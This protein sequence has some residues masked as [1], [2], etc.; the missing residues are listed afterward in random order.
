MTNSVSFCGSEIPVF[1]QVVFRQKKTT[2]FL[3]KKSVQKFCR[4]DS[5]LEIELT[6][7]FHFSNETSFE[8]E[9]D[10]QMLVYK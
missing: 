9:S 2:F 1:A 4:A 7:I 3:C 8:I 10:V 6:E 5:R